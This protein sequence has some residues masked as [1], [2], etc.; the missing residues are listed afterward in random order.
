MTQ[1]INVKKI[2]KKMEKCRR[3]QRKWRRRA[4]R[5]ERALRKAVKKNA[6]ERL[7]AVLVEDSK[8]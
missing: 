2:S 6:L 7:G 4:D 3:K 5:H 1:I 8:R